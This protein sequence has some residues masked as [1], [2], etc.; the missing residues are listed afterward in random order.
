MSTP[1]FSDLF[2]DQVIEQIY[3]LRS[4]GYDR[5]SRYHAEWLDEPELE[6]RKR[7]LSFIAPEGQKPHQDR[8]G[9]V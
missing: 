8:S 2:D 9:G 5:L 7:R 1:N 6:A 3:Q 4:P